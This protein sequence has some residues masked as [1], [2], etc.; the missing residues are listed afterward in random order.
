MFFA[1]IE[2]VYLLFHNFQTFAQMP[3]CQDVNNMYNA[4]KGGTLDFLASI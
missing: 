3:E 2:S 4:A 1:V